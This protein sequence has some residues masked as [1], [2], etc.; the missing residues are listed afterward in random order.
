MRLADMEAAIQELQMAGFLLGDNLFAVDIMRI[1][2]IVAPQKRAGYPLQNSAL[3]GIINLRGQIIP[4]MN[5][6]DRFGMPPRPADS[7]KLLIVSVAG[8]QVAL[9]VDDVDEVVTVA[10]RDL[11]PPEGMVEGI[12]SDCLIAVC[13]CNERLCLI[14]DVDALF[15]PT[16]Q[17]TQRRMQE[18]VLHDDI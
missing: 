7:G 12:G 17:N 9:A 6:R 18:D 2:E 14:L 11:L 4:V 8:R 3:D 1:K 15:V 10:V 5:L 16:G 13:L